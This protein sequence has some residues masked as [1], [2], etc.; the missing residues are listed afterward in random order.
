LAPASE[1]TA[2]P[3]KASASILFQSDDDG[4]TWQ[5]ISRGIPKNRYVTCVFVQGSEVFLGTEDNSM[6]HSRNIET[7]TWEREGVE[8]VFMNTGDIFPN[9]RITGIF[10]G[11]SGPY[12]CVYKNGFFRR[13]PGTSSW[14]SMHGALEDK[15]VHAVVESPDGTIFV[16]CTSGIYQSKDD[17]KTWKHVFAEGWVNSLAATGGV[18]VGCGSRGLLRSA[19]GGEHWDCVLPDEGGVYHTTVIGDYFAAVRV[20]GRRQSANDDIPQRAAVSTDGG[21]VWQRVDKDMSPNQRIYDLEQ[22]GKYLFCSHKAGISRSADGGKTWELVRPL[23]STNKPV[24]LELVVSGQTIFAMIVP[25]G[26]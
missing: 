21:K 26:C 20:A 11:R 22:A 13:I 5:D 18:F 8:R 3:K 24:R 23:T 19:D 7:G 9:K 14:Q 25:D 17:G 16:G 2:A 10:P 1:S 12:A 6:Y 15:E 4:K